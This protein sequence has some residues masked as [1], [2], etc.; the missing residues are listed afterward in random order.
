[1]KQ[2]VVLNDGE[3][4][5]TR[6]ESAWTLNA[7]TIYRVFQQN[8]IDTLRFPSRDIEK[9]KRSAALWDVDIQIERSPPFVV[10]KSPYA[11]HR[12]RPWV[13]AYVM[14]DCIQDA[15]CA[16]GRRGFFRTKREATVALEEEK[17]RWRKGYK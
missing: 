6:N 5:V 13:V 1:M 16:G 15:G 7:Y 9:V 8:R 10:A 4:C 12:K 3:W 17:E 11:D 14:F 2:V